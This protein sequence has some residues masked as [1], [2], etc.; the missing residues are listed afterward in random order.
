MTAAAA[1]AHAQQAKA[2]A[3]TA[4]LRPG[5]VVWFDNEDPAAVELNA[6]ELAYYDRFFTELTSAAPPRYFTHRL[7][8]NSGSRISS[9]EIQL[10]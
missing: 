3:A 8:K 2:L 6:Q 5:S 7:G 4:N 10:G 1:T 9:V